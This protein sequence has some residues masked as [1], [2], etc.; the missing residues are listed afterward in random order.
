M[1]RGR[2]GAK[3]Q[4]LHHH[5]RHNSNLQ[6]N[7]IP[8]YGSGMARKTVLMALVGM[9]V[10]GSTAGHPEMIWATFEHKNNAPNSSYTYLSTSGVKTVNPDFSTAYL[11]CAANPTISQL[12]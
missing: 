1:G 9:H 2:R 10:V 11:F 6:H 7:R 4:Q 3:P 12:K 8:I 5:E